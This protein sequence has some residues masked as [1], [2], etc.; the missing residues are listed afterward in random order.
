[1]IHSFIPTCSNDK[2]S[3][4]HF[5]VVN[6]KH[7]GFQARLYRDQGIPPAISYPNG[8]NL[9]RMIENSFLRNFNLAYDH[10]DYRE[11]VDE[12]KEFLEKLDWDKLYKDPT[13]TG[14]GEQ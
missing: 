4:A 3:V 8:W 7:V 1:L 11:R 9:E 14:F 2:D 12:D 13:Y 6:Y 5:P 10:G